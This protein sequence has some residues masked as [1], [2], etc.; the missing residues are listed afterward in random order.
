MA[1][2]NTEDKLQADPAAAKLPAGKNSVK[3]LGR[4]APDA[5]DAVTT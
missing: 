5:K 1:L 4:V 3:G 2:G